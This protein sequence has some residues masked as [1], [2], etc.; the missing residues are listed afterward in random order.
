MHAAN[1]LLLWAILIVTA[2]FLSLFNALNLTWLY[3]GVSISL[4]I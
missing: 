3:I 2:Q 4:A 1:A